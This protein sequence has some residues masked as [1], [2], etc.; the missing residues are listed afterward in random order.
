[1]ETA[2]AAVILVLAVNGLVSLVY[3]TIDAVSRWMD[4]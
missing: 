2:I 4:E 1:M 3:D